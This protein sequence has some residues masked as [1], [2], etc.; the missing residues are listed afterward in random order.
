MCASDVYEHLLVGTVDPV[1]YALAMDALDHAG[2][3][4]PARID[5]SVCSQ[6]YQPGVDPTNAQTFIQAFLALPGLAAVTTPNVNLVGASEVPA[7]PPLRC[8]VFAAGC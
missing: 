5:P 3:A 2:P 4:K 6:V 7:E 1:A 8:Y